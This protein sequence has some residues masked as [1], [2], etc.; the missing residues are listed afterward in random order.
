LSSVKTCYGS[1]DSYIYWLAR[2]S[3]VASPQQALV[4]VYD[5]RSRTGNLIRWLQV[6]FCYDIRESL[7]TFR[8][9]DFVRAV[10]K[11]SKFNRA[12]CFRKRWSACISCANLQALI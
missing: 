6:S 7:V 9:L 4:R 1:G 5:D 11:Y 2:V 3:L 8:E 10:I 12:F